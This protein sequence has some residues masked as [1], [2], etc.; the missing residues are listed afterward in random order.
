VPLFNLEQRQRAVQPLVDAGI[1]RRIRTE[2]HPDIAADGTWY[3]RH[4]P[5]YPCAYLE[6]V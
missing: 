6:L 3:F 1:V 5:G 2:A 4:M